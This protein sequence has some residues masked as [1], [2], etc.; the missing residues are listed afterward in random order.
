VRG[1]AIG[2]VW[3]LPAVSLVLFTSVLPLFVLMRGTIRASSVF[4][5]LS[6]EPVLNALRFS[7][8]QAILSTVFTLAIGSLLA[9]ILARYEFHGRRAIRVIVTVPFVLPTVVVGAAFL[10]L[11]PIS[12]ERSLGSVVLA[13]VFFN[14][15]V[16][17]RLV[18]PQWSMVD[19]DLLAAARSLGASPLRLVTRIIYPLASTSLKAAGAVVFLM[20]FTSY[21]VVRLLGGP[22]SRTIEV[23]IYRRAVILGDVSGAT[24]LAT[25]QTLAIIALFAVATRRRSVIMQRVDTDRRTAPMWARAIAYTAA[26]FIAAPLAAMTFQSIRSGGHWTTGGWTSLFSRSALIDDV[27]MFSVVTRATPKSS[28]SSTSRRATVHFGSGRRIRN[29]RHLRPVTFRLSFAMVVDSRHTRR[30]R[31]P[32]RRSDI[33]FGVRGD[34]HR[35]ARCGCRSRGV[36]GTPVVEG[37]RT[38]AR[39]GSGHRARLF[40][41]ALPRRIRSHEFSHPSKDSDTAD[42][43]RSTPRQSR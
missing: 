10:A 19:P 31:T 2:H 9:W 36:A 6:Q 24:I 23:E 40:G 39:S 18:T 1:F 20:S 28:D 41:C 17:V 12:V 16:V 37:G 25:A 15:A 32:L 5:T 29:P 35:S 42:S 8:G 11:L 7:A 33:A 21:G 13:H 38:D 34:S 30:R 27:D 14:V 26:V 43:D 22:G 4:T 3:S